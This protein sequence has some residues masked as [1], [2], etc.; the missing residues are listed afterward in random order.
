MDVIGGRWVFKKKRGRD[1]KVTRY[2]ARGVAQGFKQIHG[3]H[4]FETFA[5]T[6]KMASLRLFLAYAV[7]RSWHLVQLDV[8]TA[9]LIPK[10]PASEMIYMKPLPGMV[11]PEGHSLKLLR[12]LYGLKQ[13]ACAWNTEFDSTLKSNDE[14]RA[15]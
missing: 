5:P 14:L 4:F 9:F 8:K 12:C 7:F 10:L 11:V 13:S 3:Q 15:N 1:G 6:L 2:K